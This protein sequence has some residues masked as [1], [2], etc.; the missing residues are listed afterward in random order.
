MKRIGDLFDNINFGYTV[1]FGL[2]FALIAGCA[3]VEY[4]ATG[5]ARCLVVKCVVVK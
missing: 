3:W 2:S 4:K 1:L 5:D